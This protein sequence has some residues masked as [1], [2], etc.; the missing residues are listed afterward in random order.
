MGLH[1]YFS[2]DLVFRQYVVTSVIYCLL[3][4]GQWDVNVSK[5]KEAAFLKFFQITNSAA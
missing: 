5:E 1:F 2:T 4:V 3:S